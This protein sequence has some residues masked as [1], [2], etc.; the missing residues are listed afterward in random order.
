[1]VAKLVATAA[2]TR[3]S[4]MTPRPQKAA[5]VESRLD[6]VFENIDFLA[7]YFKIQ[8]GVSEY[9]SL[10]VDAYEN[11]KVGIDQEFELLEHGNIDGPEY[12]SRA[13]MLLFALMMAKVYMGLYS[14]DASLWKLDEYIERAKKLV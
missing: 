12:F 11:F 4:A 1:M 10:I 5:D 9:G 8:K 7:K 13:N 14:S 6:Q 2:D 3:Q